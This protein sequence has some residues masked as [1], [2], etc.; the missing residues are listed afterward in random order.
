VKDDVVLRV[1]HLS[2]R[3][4]LYTRSWDRVADWLAIPPRPRYREFWA[5][6]DV[7][8]EL[9]RGECLGIIGPNG[10]GKSTLLK[11]LTGA[12]QQTSGRLDVHGRMLSLLELGTGFNP[13]LTGRENIEYSARL[14]GFP[15]R[16][17]HE[18]TDAIEEFAEL[19]EYFDRPVKHYS[20]GM[21]VRLAFSLFS[22]MSPD[23]FLVDEA[24]AVG[25]LRF[26]AKALACVRRMLDQGTT[27]L[28]VSHD[29]QVVSQV[30]SRVLWLHAGAVQADGA[31][32]AVTRAYQQFVVHGESAPL[33]VPAPPPSGPSDR[34]VEAPSEL[35]YLGTGWHP[36]EAYA[37]EVFRWAGTEAHLIIPRSSGA[38]RELLLELEP[39]PS[40]GTLPLKL[41]AGSDDGAMADISLQGRE[42]VRLPLPNDLDIAR[43]KLRVVNGEHSAPGDD[44]VLSFR[45]LRWGWGDHGEL[46]SIQQL[47][48][49]DGE[50]RDADLRRELGAMEW[51][52][53]ACAP[54]ADA[55]ARIIRVVTCDAAGAEAT[56]FTTFEP[57]KLEVTALALA[58]VRGLVVGVQLRDMFD[59]VLW[60]TRM[61][62]QSPRL[63]NLRRG[64][65]FTATFSTDALRLGDGWYQLTVGVYEYPHE[66]TVFHWVDGAWR[67]QVVR[68]AHCSFA[69]TMDLDLHYSPAT[70]ARGQSEGKGRV[71][72]TVLTRS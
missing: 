30:C 8:F 64:E 28:F 60:G 71:D 16:H 15:A 54:I 18:R 57:L 72:V 9:C 70:S 34:L 41:Q 51:A 5:L 43:L 23:I 55:R 65:R 27:L 68:P 36:L 33:L 42:L 58:D 38:S 7:S 26:A 10:A 19:G 49:W 35:V 21:F 24:L 39:G 50:T 37:G 6:R 53:Q 29:L 13:E 47:G 44:R 11:L 45:A 20:T 63:P 2:K 22:T 40:A 25:D 67:F 62:W 31:P 3:F 56:R 1:E 17:A 59:R 66:H 14:L 4:K 61:D 46:V 32:L 52:L 12:L 69:G 48:E